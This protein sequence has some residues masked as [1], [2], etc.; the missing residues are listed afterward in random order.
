MYILKKNLLIND[1]ISYKVILI[2][3]KYNLIILFKYTIVTYQLIIKL[4][5]LMQK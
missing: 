3:V 1:Y 5:H 4:L 2:I